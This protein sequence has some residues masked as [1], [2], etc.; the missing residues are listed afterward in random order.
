MPINV[1]VDA[2]ANGRVKFAL[3]E[4]CESEDGEQRRRTVEFTMS[5][6]E[7]ETLALLLLDRAAK[8]KVE[9]A[10]PMTLPDD[11]EGRARE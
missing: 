7:A 10:V 8:S 4:E 2:L 1:W 3:L 9:L 5:A 6:G 11:G